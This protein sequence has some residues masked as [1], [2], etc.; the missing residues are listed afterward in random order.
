[1]Q[2]AMLSTTLVFT[3]HGIQTFGKW[4]DRLQALIDATP[5]SQWRRDGAC[6]VW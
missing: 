3:V 5:G 2:V 6:A 4:Q 1:M